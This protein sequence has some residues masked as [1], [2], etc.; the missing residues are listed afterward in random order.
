MMTKRLASVFLPVAA[1]ALAACSGGSGINVGNA[2]PV[3]P[4]VPINP[5][6]PGAPVISSQKH[7]PAPSPNLLVSISPTSGPAGTVVTIKAL[8]CVDANGLNHTISFNRAAG[9]GGN[10][11]DGRNPNNVVVITSTLAGT[12]LTGTYA[13]THQDTAFGGGVFFV[14]CGVTVKDQ[15]FTA[16]GH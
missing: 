9:P 16:I 2:G 1:L 5:G 4:T 7:P 14:Q 3:K 15:I 8:A 10:M 13:I 11:T 6:Q 12:V